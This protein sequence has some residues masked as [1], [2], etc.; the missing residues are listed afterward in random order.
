VTYREVIDDFSQPAEAGSQKALNKTR[1]HGLPHPLPN[2]SM[3][4]AASPGSGRISV[5][6][7]VRIQGLLQ[8]QTLRSLERLLEFAAETKPRA[9]AHNHLATRDELRTTEDRR[10]DLENELRS[11]TAEH[12]KTKA[13]LQAM[14][15]ELQTKGR[16]LE[17]KNRELERKRSPQEVGKL[18]KDQ[19]TKMESM[20]ASYLDHL[21]DLRNAL[22][23]LEDKHQEALGKEKS[24]VIRL[25]KE[26]NE[27]IRD[28]SILQKDLETD[29]KKVAKLE[30]DITQEKEKAGKL[31]EN[32]TQGEEKVE[33]LQG[34]LKKPTEGKGEFKDGFPRV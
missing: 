9:E 17:E 14:K 27:N 25:Q 32:I 16:Q 30:E 24:E 6:G 26:L 18:D 2:R 22:E 33:E 12:D 15:E 3:T 31:Q 19:N 5:D 7:H 34:K 8:P 28:A 13:N 20:K 23:N 11:E 4:D 29:K 21:V 1:R 10:D